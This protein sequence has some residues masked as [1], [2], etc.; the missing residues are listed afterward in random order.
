MKLLKPLLLAALSAC[1]SD[2]ADSH[3]P[4]PAP[5]PPMPQVQSQNGPVMTAPGLVPISFQGDLLAG[6]IDTFI[7]QMVANS[8]YW[9]G[10]TAEYGV[11]PLTSQPTQHVAEAAP[12]AITDAQVQAWLTS[13]ILSGAFPRP[14][15][16]TIYVIFYPKESVITPE[17][18][19]HY[20]GCGHVVPRARVQCLS[21]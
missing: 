8:S 15:S 18:V 10:A 11:G 13:K 16:N 7:A 12:L 17:R 20:D 14:D 4:Y 6:P 1:G 3:G 5:H 19:R 2:A 21:R 9:S